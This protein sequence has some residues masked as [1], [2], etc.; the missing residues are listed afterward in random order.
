MV[1]NQCPAVSQYA[2]GA[3]SRFPQA[4]IRWELSAYV[5]YQDELGAVESNTEHCGAGRL[6][7]A[8]LRRP[9]ITDRNATRRPDAAICLASALTHHDLTD[10]ILPRW[11][12]I[13]R[14]GRGHRPA[15]AIVAISLS[16]NTFIDIVTRSRS[17]AN[18]I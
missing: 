16:I 8:R 12:A 2:R 5:P 3:C 11:T 1:R 14:A 4:S 6:R 15:Q 13:P 9:P 18:G 17:R 7:A 10:A